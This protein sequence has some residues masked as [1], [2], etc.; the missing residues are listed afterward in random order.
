MLISIG[1]A[2]LIVA[3]FI[4]A[5]YAAALLPSSGVNMNGCVTSDVTYADGTSSHSNT[6]AFGVVNKGDVVTLH[7]NLPTEPTVDDAV[8]IFYIYH[9]VTTVQYGDEVLATYGSDIAAKGDMVCK[10][11]FQ[12]HIPDEAWGHEITITCRATENSAFNQVGKFMMYPADKAYRYY[13][14]AN[15]IGM[16]VAFPMLVFG[17]LF[18]FTFIASGSFDR[19]TRKAIYIA[20]FAILSSTWI[21]ASAGAQ[22]LIGLDGYFWTLLDFIAI[23]LIVVPILLYCYESEPTGRFGKALLAALIIVSGYFVVS[24]VLNFTNILHYSS[25]LLISHILTLSSVVLL[26]IYATRRKFS[27]GGADSLFL[28]GLLIICFSGFYDLVNFNFRRFT[29]FPGITNVQSVLPLGVLFFVICLLRSYSLDVAQKQK[30]AVQ[31]ENLSKIITRTPTGVCLFR[32]NEKMELVEANEVYFDIFNLKGAGDYRGSF[33]EMI[34]ALDPDANKDLAMLRKSF[35]GGG[36]NMTELEMSIREK[37]GRFKTV[38]ARFFYDDDD[39]TATMGV[40]DITRRKKAE[41]QLRMSEERYRLALTQSG[42][43]FFSLDVSTNTVS[44]SDEIARGFNL[45]NMVG[46]VPESFIELG[47]IEKEGEESLRDFYRR[48]VAGEESGEMVLASHIAKRHGITWMKLDF[49]SV[50][51]AEHRPVS[52]II[53]F[54]DVTEQRQSAIDSKWKQSNLVSLPSRSYVV[55]E[56]DLTTGEYLRRVGDL[57]S[58]VSEISLG[59]GIACRAVLHDLVYEDDVEAY[60]VFLDRD[61]LLS[62]FERGETSDSMECRIMQNGAGYRWTSTTVQMIEGPYSDHVLIQLLVKDIHNVKTQQIDMEQNMEE[63]EKNLE[64]SRIRVMMNQIQPHFLYNSL[65]AIQAIVQVDPDY[66]SKLIYDFTV[67]LRSSIRALSSDDPIP[68]S[69]ELKNIKAYLAIE[70]MRLEDRLKIVYDITCDDFKVAPLSVQPLVENAVRHGVYPKGNL[71]GTVTLRT[72]E[73]D[74]DFVVEVIDDGDG[75]DVDEAL[76]Q[77]SDSIGLKNLIFRL[78]AIMDATVAIESHEGRGT[79]VTVTIPKTGSGQGEG[80]MS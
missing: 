32:S 65:S 79:V 64:A 8:M 49:V 30:E 48:I 61:R 43:V 76:N 31:A 78:K 22:H 41:E 1:K 50:F 14:D 29:A 67:H 16:S 58:F 36:E 75:F 39:E 23:F 7:V 42:K 71:G 47:F 37:G 13:F 46:N 24:S 5:F 73:T 11:V 34:R 51:D 56:Y 20:L 77:K 15:P 57:F 55:L 66:A 63:L 59:Y 62:A 28:T 60:R 53:T 80:E 12:V 72:Y 45:P 69:D 44:L 27:G 2:V 18:L 10:N 17:I 26:L 19:D 74:T 3:V 35:E 21:L 38:L 68:F 40:V 25:T 6:N 54:E 52:S 33:A 70:Q 9:S 4:G